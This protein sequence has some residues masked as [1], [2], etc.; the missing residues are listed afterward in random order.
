M[1]MH[2]FAKP[3]QVKGWEKSVVFSDFINKRFKLSTKTPISHGFTCVKC[4]SV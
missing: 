2:T 1:K 3:L 4:K